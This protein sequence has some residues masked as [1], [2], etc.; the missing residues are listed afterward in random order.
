M[1]FIILGT[2]RSPDIARDFVIGLAQNA[3]ARRHSKGRIEATR[4]TQKREEI[5]VEATEKKAVHFLKIRRRTLR[6]AEIMVELGA[7]NVE[8]RRMRA[9][10]HKAL[11]A[12]L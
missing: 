3:L 4:K 8:R 6:L 11:R 12:R 7:I 2:N 10:D 1:P 9:Y 5:V